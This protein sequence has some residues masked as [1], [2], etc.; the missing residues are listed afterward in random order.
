MVCAQWVLLMRMLAAVPGP[1]RLE[2][3]QGV[4]VEPVWGGRSMQS[5]P[6]EMWVPITLLGE[7]GS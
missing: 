6:H 4:L 3:R 2:A 5:T 1:G 7:M